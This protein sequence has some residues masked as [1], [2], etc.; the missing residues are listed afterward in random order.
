MHHGI[1]KL[2]FSGYNLI[3]DKSDNIINP[4]LSIKPIDDVSSVKKIF[5]RYKLAKAS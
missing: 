4:A 2:H 5:V 3:L 1:G